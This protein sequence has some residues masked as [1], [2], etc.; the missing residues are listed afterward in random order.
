MFWVPRMF[1]FKYFIFEEFPW[2]K[3]NNIEIKNKKHKLS[4]FQ[5]KEDQQKFGVTKKI[6]NAP[7]FNEIEGLKNI[8]ITD[9]PD[10]RN[11]IKY[12]K[13]NKKKHR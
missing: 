12:S 3:E 10:R 8:L 5:T 4:R 13:M 7:I 1:N 11:Q 2:K 9:H 6:T